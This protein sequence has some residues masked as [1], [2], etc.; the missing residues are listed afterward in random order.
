[1]SLALA[2]VLAEELQSVGGVPVHP[3][4]VHLPVVFVPLAFIGA[5]LGLAVKRWRSWL[6]PLTAVFAGIGLVGV[7]LAIMSGEG[8]EEL[9]DEESRAIEHHS[10]L[11]EQARPL[12][13]VFFVV[14]VL[15]AVAWH[16]MRK[17]EAAG[18]D[19]DAGGARSGWAKALLPL[20]VVS[21]LTGALS[22][23]WVYNTGHTG[24]KSAW[25]DAGKEK[26]KGEGGG[27]QGTS[28]EQG[29]S[30]GD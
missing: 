25:G 19:G 23:A 22:T 1:M 18:A 3:L 10:Q 4:L 28:G 29:D 2:P 17:D 30:D 14:T 16:L 21:I 12:V 13:F 15:V 27:D 20:M 9:L 24:A 5:I 7:Q 26:E 8:L 6:L 11:A